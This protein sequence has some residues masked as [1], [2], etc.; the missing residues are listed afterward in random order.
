LNFVL[1]SFLFSRKTGV[2]T[3]LCMFIIFSA[4]QVPPDCSDY[5]VAANRTTPPV[6]SSH[7]YPGNTGNPGKL[8]PDLINR[9]AAG[10]RKSSVSFLIAF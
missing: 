8:N 3:A 7:L 6:K 10:I 2:F 4:C 9:V 5:P 1:F